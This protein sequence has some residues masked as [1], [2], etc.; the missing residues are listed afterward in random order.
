MNQK[1]IQV[2]TDLQADLDLYHFMYM[3]METWIYN[4]V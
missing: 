2:Y 3:Y 1:V 4:D